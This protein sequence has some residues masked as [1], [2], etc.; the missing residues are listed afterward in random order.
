LEQQGHGN[1]YGQQ[2]HEQQQQQPVA[3]VLL[4]YSQRPVS[5]E[6]AEVVEDELRLVGGLDDYRSRQCAAC[7]AVHL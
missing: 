5:S 1:A 6:V 7:P 4:P 3:V 2:Q